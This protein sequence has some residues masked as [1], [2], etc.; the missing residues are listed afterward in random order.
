MT[1]LTVVDK[2]ATLLSVM[3]MAVL[4]ELMSSGNTELLK[5]AR[6]YPL[7]YKVYWEEMGALAGVVK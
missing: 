3:P 7:P 5:Y 4:K 6:P 2:V 1:E